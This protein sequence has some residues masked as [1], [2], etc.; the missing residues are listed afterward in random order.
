MT[1]TDT[2]ILIIGGG[3]A[4]ASAA[5]HLARQGHRVALLERN[6]IASEA[7][8]VNAGNIGAMG[9]GNRPNLNSYLTMGSLEIFKS[10]QLDLNYDIEFRQSGCVEAIQTPE[11]Y[12]YARA[13]V[14]RLKAAGYS[15]DLM[16]TREGRSLEPG[17]N[18]DL[19][20]LVYLPLRAQAD[21][22]KATQA[23]ADAAASE[24][25]SILTGHP[26]TAVSRQAN[27]TFQ[28]ETN[29]DAYRSRQLVIA[30]GAWCRPV[31]EMLGLDI[32]IFPV[33]G[34]MWA[35]EALAPH[36]FQTIS[37]TESPLQWHQDSG[38]QPGVPPELTHRGDQRVTR[39]LYGR[40]R[41]NGEVIFGGDRQLLGYDPGTD[42]TGVEVN[43]GHAIELFP[44]LASYPINRVWSGLMPF[45]FDGKPIIG[46]IPQVDNLFIVSGLCSSGF[47]RGPMAGKLLA[48]LM[49]DGSRPAPMSEAD[50]ARC[51]TRQE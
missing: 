29:R 32:P 23:L 51:I 1:T 18:P 35:T 11:E 49:H 3:I 25:A 36:I 44:D 9:W 8:G 14:L 31:G 15:L 24:G 22:R 20:G 12:E 27:G 40:Q 38:Q 41:R 39:H 37:A 16:T 10:L 5:Y 6:E 46:A 43:R 17:I 21:P 45:S 2:E 33:R 13:M 26:V 50:P 19:P 34:Q 7:S 47:G 30:A 28:V 42:A 48:D 4:G